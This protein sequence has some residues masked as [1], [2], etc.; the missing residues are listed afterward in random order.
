MPF[1]EAGT[2]APSPGPARGAKKIAMAMERFS[3]RA[4][5]A[6]SYAVSLAETLAGAGWEVHLIGRSWDGEPPEAVFHPIRVPA[7]LPPSAQMLLFALRHRRLVAASDFDVVL[8]FGNTLVMDVYQSHGG[9][10]WI[11]T[12]RK[13]FSEPTPFRRT[14]KRLLIR[15]TPKQWVRHFIESAAFRL[16]PQPRIIAISDMVSRDMQAA[17]GVAPEAIRVVYNG[18]DTRRYSPELRSRLRGPL[19]RRMGISEDETVFLLVSYD[20]K[21]KGIQ[22]LVEAAGMLQKRCEGRF[23]VVVVGGT[24]NEALRRRI[25]ALGLKP[26]FFFEGRTPSAEAYFAN[27]DAFVLPTYYDACSLVVFEAMACRLPVVTTDANGAAGILKDGENGF[28]ID[29]PPTAEALAEKMKRLLDPSVR[30]AMAAAAAGTA[31]GCSIE[32]NHRE[33]VRVLEAAAAGR[34][35][36]V[37]EKGL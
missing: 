12:A 9:V 30:A 5:G 11:S 26:V 16:R 22:P 35:P 6:E 21:K 19:R 32:N 37:T 34:R 4:G 17:Y 23:R 1:S 10:H 25:R 7:F 15:L 20:L 14:I 33:M 36:P 28:V 27:A 3:R 29:H 31:E 8:G 2:G 24:P 13:V 18:V